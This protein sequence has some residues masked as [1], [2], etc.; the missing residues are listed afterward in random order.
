MEP[1]HP[2]RQ[3]LVI[4]I[5]YSSDTMEPSHPPRQVL[6]I[7]IQYSSPAN[8]NMYPLSVCC[9]SVSP[10]KTPNRFLDLSNVPPRIHQQIKIVCLMSAFVCLIP[11]FPF[12]KSKRIKH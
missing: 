9:S 5:Q 3:V 11:F 1:S 7:D 2:P 4:D 12:Y 8:N 6:V 10:A